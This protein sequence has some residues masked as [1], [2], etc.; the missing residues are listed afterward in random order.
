MTV[1]STESKDRVWLCQLL[2]VLALAESVNAV[3]QPL[4]SLGFDEQNPQILEQNVSEIEGTAPGSDFFEQALRLLNLP[5]ESASVEHVQAL[6]M[7]VL[8]NNQLNRQKTAY[9]Y[10]GQSARLCNMLQ[11]HRQSSSRDC[12]PVEREHQKRIWWSTYSLDRMTSTSTGFLPTLHFE[13]T[14]L[15]YPSNIRLSAEDAQEFADPD[16]LTARI[17]LTIIEANNSAS[18]AKF[19]DADKHDI[20]TAIHPLLISLNTWKSALPA[21]MAMDMADGIFQSTRSLQRARSLAN[22]HL[23]WN[24]VTLLLVYF[25]GIALTSHSLLYY[26]LDRFFSGLC[27]A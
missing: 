5:F 11:L 14:D 1:E 23:R 21:H 25:K 20:E 18:I 7:I 6:N 17:Q 3:R 24:Q 9:M 10:A 22:F 4:I 19:R 13:Q 26:S 15:D 8:Y 12:H 2:I 16:Y 27:H